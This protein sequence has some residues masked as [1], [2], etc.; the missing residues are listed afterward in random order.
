MKNLSPKNRLIAISSFALVLVMAI[1]FMV[2]QNINTLATVNGTRITNSQLNEW[3]VD[4]ISDGAKD[5]P[6]LRQAL[7]NRLIFR[8]AAL[9]NIQSIGLLS[10]GSNAFKVRVAPQKAEIE[11]WFARYFKDHPITDADLKT[12]YDLQVAANKSSRNA[13]QYQVLQIVVNTQDEANQILG[14]LKKGAPF[15]S[16]AKERSTDKDSGSRGGMVGWLFISQTAPPIGEVISGLSKG[17]IG[18]Q[19]VQTQYGWHIIKVNDIKPATIASFEQ[20]KGNLTQILVQQRRQ[21]AIDEL[22]KN[23]KV[24]RSN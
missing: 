4:A 19:A 12:Q 9:Q 24:E 6:E 18:P 11:L 8:E 3:V 13:Y 22:L 2:Y 5:T 15:E 23:T 16:V 20:S 14:Q 21:E 7:L 10:E 1:G 17:Q